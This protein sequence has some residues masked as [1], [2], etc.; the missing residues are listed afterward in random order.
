MLIDHMLIANELSKH[1]ILKVHSFRRFLSWVCS[2]KQNAILLVYSLRC[3]VKFWRKK[4]VI[5]SHRSSCKYLCIG[6]CMHIHYRV[7]ML[8]CM[9]YYIVTYHTTLHTVLCYL[10]HIDCCMVHC[11]VFTKG[12]I[13]E[14]K[15]HNFFL[16]FS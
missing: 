16:N 11:V 9:P 8:H 7:F 2:F 5:L 10:Y 15:L 3:T 12:S 4:K 13:T 14:A 1:T 6:N